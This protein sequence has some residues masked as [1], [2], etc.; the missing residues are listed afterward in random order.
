MTAKEALSLIRSSDILVQC[1][2]GVCSQKTYDE[3]ASVLIFQ[4]QITDEKIDS[5][6]IR[7]VCFAGVELSVNPYVEDGKI[8]PVP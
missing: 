6:T 1:G 5:S 3:I 2:R 4:Q 7:N 8:I